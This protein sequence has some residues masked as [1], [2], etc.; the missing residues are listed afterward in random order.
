MTH[1]VYLMCYII[2]RLIISSFFKYRFK[3]DF[4]GG[5]SAVTWAAYKG[6]DEVLQLLLDNEYQ[7][8][9]PSVVADFGMSPILWAAGRGHENCVKALITHGA[10]VHKSDKFGS[11]AIFWACRK[12]HLGVVKA[13]LKADVD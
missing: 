11:T 3:I 2:G 13:L 8:G 9:D 6:H 1:T 10:D 4:K 7:N 12:G 5:W